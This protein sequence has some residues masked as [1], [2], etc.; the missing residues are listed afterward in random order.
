MQPQCGV[1]DYFLK[2]FIVAGQQQP[3]QWDS[4]AHR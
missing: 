4:F 2:R 1:I 3:N